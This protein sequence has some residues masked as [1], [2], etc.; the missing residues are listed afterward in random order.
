MQVIVT[1][2]A[3]DAPGWVRGLQ[4]AGY[5]P[6]PLPLIAIGPVPDP[7]ALHAVWQ[8]LP[9][10]QALMFVSGNAVAHFYASK[11]P[12]ALVKHEEFAIKSRV[13]ATGPGT[14][15]A[16]QA[17]GVASALIDAPDASAGQFDSE[18]LWAVVQGQVPAGGRVL[19][20]RGA[21]V[22]HS[23]EPSGVT[24]PA[25]AQPNQAS[26]PGVGRDWLA[27]Q[28]SGSGVAVDFVVAYQR[29]QPVLD[30]EQAARAGAAASDGS[31]WLFSSS[32][33]VAN[34]RHWLPRQSWAQA[35]AVATHAR[36]AQAAQAAGFGVVCESR[37][38]LASVVASIESLE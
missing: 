2:P 17:A 4:A 23:P 1:R 35:R 26:Q 36:I 7:S 34:L 22:P 37:P 6:W 5:A 9:Q 38:A 18:T 16:L 29:S 33:A 19:I 8:Q 31:V 27:N 3:G 15:R 25:I 10:Y 24:T 13:W 30:A 20:V 11:P 14:V 32:E 21:D 12:F 28:L